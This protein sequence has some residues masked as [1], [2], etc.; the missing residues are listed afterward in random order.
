MIQSWINLDLLQS[1]T[2]LRGCRIRDTRTNSIGIITNLFKENGNDYIEFKWD[3][4]GK[5]ISCISDKHINCYWEVDINKHLL[6]E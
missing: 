2:I 1:S 3:G 6:H 5:G 4:G